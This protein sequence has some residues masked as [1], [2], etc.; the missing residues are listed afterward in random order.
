MP[1]YHDEL[2]AAMRL[3]AGRPET[4]FIGQGVGVG[5]TSMWST[6]K[7]LPADK[8]LEFP[9]AEDLQAGMAL[10]MALGGFLPV[11]IF[12]RWNFLICAANQIVNHLDRLALYSDGG[13]RPRVLIRVATPST[14][15][16]NPGPQH[17]DDFSY[18]FA[19]ALRTIEV[20]PLWEASTIVPAY[21][22]ALEYE[23]ST[24]LVEYTERYADQRHDAKSG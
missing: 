9:V 23:G 21:K 8:R 11:C 20:V 17:D 13:Y 12:P 2:C 14:Q 16:F 4:I 18:L 3:L 15:G 5:G 7:D 6:L 10:G 24:I 1:I 22:E 19:S